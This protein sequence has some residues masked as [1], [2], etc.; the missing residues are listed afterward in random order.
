MVIMGINK[1]NEVLLNRYLCIL[2]SQADT[3]N[4]RS[5]T[6]KNYKIDIGQFLTY[7]QDEDCTQIEFEVAHAWIKSL[8]GKSGEPVKAATKNRKLSSLNGFYK[9]LIEQDYC[10]K[11]PFRYLTFETISKGDAHTGEHG[12]QDVRDMMDSEEVERFKKALNKEV[13][14]PQ[15]KQGCIKENAK[16]I[17]LRDKAMFLLMLSCG[18]RV[19]EVID[20]S[21]DR[22]TY[23]EYEGHRIGRVYIPKKK[24]KAKRGRYVPVPLEVMKAIESYRKSLNFNTDSDRVFLSQRGNRLDVGTLDKRIKEYAELAKINKH[25]TAHSL[26]HTCATQMIY[27]GKNYSKI[28]QV[29]GHTVKTLEETYLHQT[30]DSFDVIL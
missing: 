4:K 1:N 25:L 18:L 20:L 22:L 15:M 24:D 28:A 21:V 17:A 10:G 19:S 11:N 3:D 7:L 2:E 9:F 23:T 6:L 26:R 8:K 12:N 29:L 16:M 14:N 13:L 27:S 30:N 5:N